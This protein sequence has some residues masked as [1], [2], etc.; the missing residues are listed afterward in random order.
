M[1]LPVPNITGKP[2]RSTT[3]EKAA[4]TAAAW[5]QPGLIERLSPS[6]VLIDGESRFAAADHG[7][8]HKIR[9]GNAVSG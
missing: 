6:Q 5:P 2:L 4:G 9:A 3:N 7:G 1:E 8:H